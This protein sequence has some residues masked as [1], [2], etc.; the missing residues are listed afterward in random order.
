MPYNSRYYGQGKYGIRK[1]LGRFAKKNHLG[2]KA[3][4]AG[5][6]AAATYAGA[7]M[8]T[9]KGKYFQNQNDLIN[10]VKNR[11]SGSIPMFSSK[12]DETG[13]LTISHREY[14]RDIYGNSE[15]E[16]FH[17]QG[18]DL[19][20]GLEA[21]FPWLSQVA[22]NFEEYDFKQLIFTYRS[23]IADVSSNNGQVGTVIATTNYNPSENIFPNKS[24]MMGYAHTM[25][26]KTTEAL[27]HGVECD[28]KKLSGSSGKYVRS[29][30]L[31]PN[32]DVKTYDHGK[33]Q[34]AIANTPN[35]IADNTIGELWVSYTVKLRKPKYHTKEGFGISRDIFRNA[36]WLG[37]YN[38]SNILSGGLLRGV[39]NSIGCDVFQ[40]LKDDGSGDVQKGT[41]TVQ[42]PAHY[43]GNLEITLRL[44]AWENGFAET[45]TW[46]NPTAA[47]TTAGNVVGVMDIVG[48]GHS[49][50]HPNLYS[51]QVSVA[52][53][54]QFMCMIHVR[55]DIASNA[56]DN[57]VTIYF[58]DQTGTLGT[59]ERFLTNDGNVYRATVVEVSEYNSTFGTTASSTPIYMDENKNLVP[60]PH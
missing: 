10:S 47:V 3:F 43:A 38:R 23:T 18:I 14:I 34:L 36:D 46:D 19:N 24:M 57:S 8:Y 15:N 30:G 42:F 28:P 60:L 4:D 48:T 6:K 44:V 16:P 5:M 45:K 13:E 33:F 7:G 2:Q 17:N 59:T 11:S 1:T 32:Q 53:D 27:M 40:P 29:Q 37:S 25:S 56:V 20:P 49:T 39:H 22:Q 12:H 21:S 35:D 41:L 26:Q 55:V 9:G 52:D 50:T 54:D 51:A 58:D 31:D